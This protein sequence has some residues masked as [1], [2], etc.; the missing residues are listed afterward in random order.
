MLRLLFVSG[1]YKLEQVVNKA[2]TR[3]E[4][5]EHFMKKEWTIHE[6]VMKTAGT[7]SELVMTSQEQ[8]ANKVMNKSLKN[9]E[10][11]KGKS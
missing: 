8:I 11:V 3:N 6:P 4:K 2:S 10:Q 9:Y 7:S 5:N 1:V